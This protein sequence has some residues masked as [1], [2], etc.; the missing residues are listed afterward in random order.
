MVIDETRYTAAICRN[1][2]ET[3]NAIPKR[4][5]HIGLHSAGS[6]HSLD[7]F[8]VA[9]HA[10][11]NDI[12]AH[13]MRVLD[14]NSQSASFWYVVRCNEQVA[15]EVATAHSISVD[16]L[17]NLSERLKGIRDQT[18]F[19]IDRDAV[20]DARAVW[21]DAGITGNDLG[22]ALDAVFTRGK[23]RPGLQTGVSG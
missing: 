9:A 8:L 20:I 13:A 19:H 2:A 10:L 4:R 3:N 22:W 23:R 7:F 11:Y 15:N 21:D 1:L 5:A 16:R 14:R 17:R 18:H 12:L 6:A